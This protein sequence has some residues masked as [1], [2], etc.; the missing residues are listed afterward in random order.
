MGQVTLKEQDMGQVTFT[1]AGHRLAGSDWFHNLPLVLLG[2]RSVPRKDSLISPSATV[3]GSTMVLLCSI[4]IALS[5]SNE[6]N[7][8]RILMLLRL[9]TTQLRHLQFQHKFLQV[10]SDQ[11]MFLS[12]KM[13][14]NLFYLRSTKV[15][16]WCFLELQNIFFSPGCFQD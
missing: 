5:I 14:P 9:I 15:R 7:R 13:L 3:L 16:T 8:K 11:L 12:E 10:C 2:L 6:S 1:G 4:L